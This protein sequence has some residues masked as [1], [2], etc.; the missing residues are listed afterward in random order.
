MKSGGQLQRLVT[1]ITVLIEGF[2][3]QPFFVKG[4]ANKGNLLDYSKSHYSILREFSYRQQ[5]TPW[6]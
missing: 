5:S 1:F 3:N 6:S 4:G 2:G